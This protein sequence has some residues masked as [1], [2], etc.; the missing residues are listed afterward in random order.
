[1]HVLQYVTSMV[2][3][4]EDGKRGFHRYEP[5]SDGIFESEIGC[6]RAT[7]EESASEQREGG[8]V[9]QARRLAL[10]QPRILLDL[11]LQQSIYLTF[12]P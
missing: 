2:R 5:S 3:R 8:C 4:P 11:Y 7:Q 9:P 6:A 12:L 10:S 1:M